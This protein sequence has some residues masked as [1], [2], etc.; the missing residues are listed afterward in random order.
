VVIL[1]FSTSGFL[2]K[3][4]GF[5]D[6]LVLNLSNKKLMATKTIMEIVMLNTISI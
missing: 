2:F 3:F 4:E 6:L 1:G 5:S